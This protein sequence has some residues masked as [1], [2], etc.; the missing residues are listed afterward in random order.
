MNPIS[1]RSIYET[2]VIPTLLFGCENWV[3]TDSMLHQLESFQGEIGRRILKLSRHHS[4]L[5]M[6]LGLRWPSITTRI[7]ISKLSLLTKLSEGEGTIGSQIF[8]SLPQGSLRLMQECRHLKE[9]LSCRGCTDSLLNSQSSLREKKREILQT[10]WDSCIT[11]ASDHCSMAIAAQIAVNVRLWDMALDYGPRGTE[12]LQALYRELTG[13]QFW[14]GI[15]HL[16][17]TPFNGPYLHHFT[18]THTRL[19]DP[20]RIISSLSCSDSDIFMYTKYSSVT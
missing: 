12:C 17:D 2:C 9:K 16:C 3:L 20:E 11:E 15:C 14:K 7:L 19:S 6:R 18:L 1:G 13:P 8:S 10:D 4:T 5:S